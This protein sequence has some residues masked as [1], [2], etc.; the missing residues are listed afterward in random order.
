[1]PNIFTLNNQEL[2][3]RVEE[4]KP[5]R[6]AVVAG[7]V[8][9]D[10]KALTSQVVTGPFTLLGTG[11]VVIED[12]TEQ[13]KPAKKKPAAKKPAPKKAPAKKGKKK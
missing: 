13:P 3:I 5:Q 6:V 1:M 12:A 8:T 10:G 9:L 11:R 4:D 7:E 2:H